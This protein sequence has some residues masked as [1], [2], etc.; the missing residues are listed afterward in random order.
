M[1][2]DWRHCSQDLVH[3]NLKKDRFYY[4]QAQAWHLKGYLLGTHS[5]SVMW[6]NL[7]NKFLVIE[8]TD[9]ETLRHQK[10]NI[11]YLGK[12]TSDKS[13]H[14]VGISDRPY[15]AQ[16]FGN[17]PYIVDSDIA[18]DYK[19]IYSAVMQ[20]PINKFKLL[21]QNCNTFTSYLHWKLELDIKRP[22]RSVGYKNK[23]WWQSNYGT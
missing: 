18:V 14:I 7:Y 21:T 4:I 23:S 9:V 20:Y 5:Y 6:N 11:L 16:W 12:E 15:N 22:I 1:F 10:C 3:L 13:K 2:K 19:D 17:N 8:L